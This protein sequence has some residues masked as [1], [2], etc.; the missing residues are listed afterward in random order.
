[1]DRQGKKGNWKTRQKK[2]K[3]REEADKRGGKQ[4]TGKRQKS[5]I[6][7]TRQ[8]SREETDKKKGKN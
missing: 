1:M 7:K 8:K 2:G 3:S 4:K 6:G 5:R